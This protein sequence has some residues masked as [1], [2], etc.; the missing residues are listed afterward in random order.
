MEIKLHGVPA[1]LSGANLKSE[2]VL[3]QMHLHWGAEHTVDGL[4]AP[5]ELH[6][7]H[8]DKQYANFSIATQHEDGVAVVSILFKVEIII[9]YFYFFF[10]ILIIFS[11]NT[12]L[13]V[14]LC[15]SSVDMII[16]S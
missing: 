4:R 8:Y 13:I 10:S 16:H 6:L 14:T 2:Y 3:E 7:V 11:L 9:R 15:Y 12:P 5:L 1:H